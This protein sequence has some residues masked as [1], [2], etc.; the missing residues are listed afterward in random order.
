MNIKETCQ[1]DAY[2]VKGEDKSAT[3]TYN[4]VISNVQQITVAQA[5]EIINGLADGGITTETYQVSGTISA[6]KQN[7]GTTYGTAEFTLEGGLVAFRLNYLDNQPEKTEAKL[8]VTDEVIIQGQ[9]QKYVTGGTTTPEMV[10]GYV[11]KHVPHGAPVVPEY[12]GHVSIKDFLAAKDEVNIYELTGV[13][14]SIVNTTYGNLYIAEGAD[15]LYIYGVLDKEGKTQ[16]FASL[17]VEEKDTLTIRGTYTTYNE[18]PQVK[19]A[20]FIS[21]AKYSDPEPGP[22]PGPDPEPSENLLANGDFELWS[23]EA[24]PT[25]WKSE[26]T[27]SSAT[28]SQSTEARGGSYAV[29]VAGTASSN[30]RL[31]YREMEFKPGKYT[32]SFY[33][34]ATTEDPCQT[35]GGYVP[36]NSEG[37]LGNYV[38]FGYTNINNTEWTLVSADFEVKETTIICLVVMNPKTSTYSTS[39]DIL[40]DDASLITYGGGVTGVEGIAADTPEKAQDDA[41]YTIDGIRHQTLVKGLN[42]VGGKKVM[43]K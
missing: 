39:Q 37:K 5:L 15:T 12:K 14:T 10:K 6:I 1:L 19:N 4:Y 32:F 25:N 38:Y 41:I 24:T 31:A 16:N 42:I 35:Q 17:G 8:A 7:F 29:S 23:D 30:K 2:A 3:V 26:C 11:V 34:K 40:I 13:V 36:I 28:L 20:Q 43:V 18:A 21:V 22:G 9:L 27:A 33:A